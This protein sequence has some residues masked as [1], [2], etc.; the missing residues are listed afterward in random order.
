MA[1]TA[2]EADEAAAAAAT[3]AAA[4]AATTAGA[5]VREAATR[6]QVTRVCALFRQLWSEDPADPSI[7]PV[8]LHALTQAGN[9]ASVAEA[10]GRLVGACVGFLGR[11]AAGV[12]LHSHITGVTAAARGRSVGFALKTHQRAWALARGLDTISWTY[13]PLVARNAY[14]NLTKLAARP[15]AYHVDFYGPMTDGINAGDESDRL[16]AQW[17]LRD[18][19]VRR[20]CA[21]MPDHHDTDELLAAGAVVAL[22]EGDGRPVEKATPTTNDAPL[23]VR[24]PDDV[25]R[26]RAEERQAATAW[27]HA[28]RDVLGGLMAGGASVVGFA[29]PGW[30]VVQRAAR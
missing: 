25:E 22:A 30:Y 2:P 17:R 6:D 27:R 16:M 1:E 11:T 26:L 9:Y 19:A 3:A 21:G 28:V 15:R 5:V 7:T 18:D 12:E 8:L 20:A 29:R 4:A 24:V 23:L 13:D 10:D 14:F